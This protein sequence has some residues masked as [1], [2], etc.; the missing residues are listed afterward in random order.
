M[1]IGNREL[2]R[3]AVRRSREPK[4]QILTALACLEEKD[5]IARVQIRQGVQQQV[6]T[7]RLLFR[8]QLTLLVG[9]RKECA[10]I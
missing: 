10:K 6:V 4:V 3:R 5:D 1:Q 7:S 2:D 8:I 9:V